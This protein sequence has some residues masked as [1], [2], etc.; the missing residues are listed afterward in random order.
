M[1]AAAAGRASSSVSGGS[2]T[3]FEQLVRF[4]ELH[5]LRPV[6]GARFPFNEVR[7]AYDYLVTGK[8]MGKVVID[9]E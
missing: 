9:F 6:I 1:A 2:R 7:A 8:P 5:E 3:S 4:I